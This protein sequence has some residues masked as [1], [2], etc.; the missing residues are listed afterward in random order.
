MRMPLF[1]GKKRWMLPIIGI[2]LCSLLFS[3]CG[4]NGSILDTAGPVA[5]RE[6]VLFWVI[7]GIATFIFVGVE[8]ALIYSIVR[9]RERPGMPNP[10]QLHGNLTVEIIWTVI[11]ALVLFVVLGFTIQT[12]F[13]VAA[14]PA[15]NAVQ[16]EAIGHQ[17]W[18]EFYYP[19]YKITTADSLVV[20]TGQ[21]IHVELFSNN[22]IHSFWVPQ[23]TGKTDVVPGHDNT[24]WFQADKE[25][26][27]AGMCTEYCGDQHAHMNF[28]VVA[29]NS[30]DFNTWVTKQ[31]Q[32]GLAPAAGSAADNGQKIY[33]QQCYVCHG[34]KGSGDSK[35]AS[36]YYD[37]KVYCDSVGNNV[38]ANACKVGP[39]LTHFGARGLIAGGV[40]TNNTDA[41][42]PDQ[43]PA[44]LLQNCHLAQWLND[45]QGIKPGNDMNIGQLTP[46][47]ISDLVAYL[48]SLT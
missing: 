31:Q 4:G 14:Q 28:E 21:T 32:D 27:Y 19:D 45:P 10:R 41:C 3:A 18:W 2:A 20:P 6:R 15:G 24:K 34:I 47:Q 16:V 13:A 36:R 46:Q 30:S 39:N 26:T 25:G 23:L 42:G 38:D 7:L 35:F 22:V 48:E 40:L 37:P 11:P 12:L 44:Q 29:K 1:R 43:T 5:D 33:L 8:G 9:F 17:W